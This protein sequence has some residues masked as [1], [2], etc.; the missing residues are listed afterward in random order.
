MRRVGLGARPPEEGVLAAAVGEVRRRLVR[1]GAVHQPVR[2]RGGAARHLA[3]AWIW[4]APP[5]RAEPGGAATLGAGLCVLRGVP[6][7]E[8]V[9]CLISINGASCAIF[10][11]RKGLSS[12]DWRNEGKVVSFTQVQNLNRDGSESDLC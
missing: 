6:R 9:R 7:V 8:L 1:H 12:A 5:A 11:C 2:A 3:G 4:C 10:W